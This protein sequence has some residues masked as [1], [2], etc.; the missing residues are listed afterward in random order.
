[1]RTEE[2][3]SEI[4]INSYIAQLLA[5]NEDKYKPIDSENVT[6]S[7]KRNSPKTENR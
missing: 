3:G 2:D 1:V 6:D 4:V 5:V 7:M